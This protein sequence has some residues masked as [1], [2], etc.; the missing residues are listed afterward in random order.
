MKF[1]VKKCHIMTIARGRT[2]L[3]QSYTLKGEVLSSVSSAKYLGITLTEELSWS[4]H[5]NSVFKRA[6]STLG[7][8]RRN[9]RRC[10]AKLKER[11]YI[12]LVRSSMEYAAAVWDPHLKKDI[13]MLE[14]V[15]RR[16]ARFAVGDYKTTSSVT[17]MLHDLGWKDLQHRRRDLR[18]AMMYKICT[19]HVGIG[20]Q[21]VGLEGADER[22]RANHK[23]KFRVKGGSSPALRHSF[24]VRTVSEWNRLPE[25]TV[26][27]ETP[28]AFKAELARQAPAIATAHAP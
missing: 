4:T 8:L 20:P 26:R 19:G 5:S 16:A 21:D 12:S 9:L 10:P 3:S 24:A 25:T 6:N 7:F 23:F 2:R 17:Q 14:S 1:N 22:T 18:L 11:A 15:Q 13:H 27:Q 28:E